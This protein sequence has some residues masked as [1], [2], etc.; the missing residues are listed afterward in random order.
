MLGRC[1]VMSSGP[2]VVSAR[3]R[4]CAPVSI[5]EA[6]LVVETYGTKEAAEADDKSSL[7]R[8][9]RDVKIVG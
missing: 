1:E 7:A 8:Y 3:F 2:D 6:R 5:G 4:P 9:S